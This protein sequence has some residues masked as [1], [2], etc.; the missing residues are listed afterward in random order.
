VVDENPSR[1]YAERAKAELAARPRERGRMVRS[2]LHPDGTYRTYVLPP[3]GSAL[4]RINVPADAVRWRSYATNDSSVQFHLEQGTVPIAGDWW[5]TVAAGDGQFVEGNQEPGQCS[6]ESEVIVTA[7]T[8]IMTD[9][10]DH[11]ENLLHDPQRGCLFMKR[12]LLSALVGKD[13]QTST[14]DF[15]LRQW[16]W[17]A[18][19]SRPKAGNHSETGELIG[20]IQ[21]TFRIE[22]DWDLE[23]L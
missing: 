7:Y 5:C 10:T 8:R 17:A 14:G 23:S 11:A 1:T 6:E 13:L 4:F 12:K 20:S 19:S 2:A 22:F 3:F 16:L 18:R 21:L 15:F 9:R